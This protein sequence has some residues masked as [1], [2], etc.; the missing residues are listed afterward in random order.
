LMENDAAAEA[1]LR[2][3]L[4]I[5]EQLF[6]LDHPAT[7]QCVSKLGELFMHLHLYEQAKMLYQRFL[8]QPTS[9]N[10]NL[11]LIQE[12]YAF[13]LDRI[14]RDASHA[15]SRDGIHHRGSLST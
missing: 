7:W 11:A 3:S 13:L 14:D 4:A 15:P 8:Q 10:S 12:Q 1:L 5:Y 6:G 2:Q 9:E